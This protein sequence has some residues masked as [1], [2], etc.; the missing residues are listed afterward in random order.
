MLFILFK[1]HHQRAND[2]AQKDPGTNPANN[3]HNH[4]PHSELSC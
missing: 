1:Q 2:N 4:L 3:R